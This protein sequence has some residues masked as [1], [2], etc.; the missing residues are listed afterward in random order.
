MC[1]GH[2]LRYSVALFCQLK[3]KL[4]LV[5][6]LMQNIVK[7]HIKPVRLN[8]CLTKLLLN[9]LK[10]NPLLLRLT[11]AVLELLNQYGSRSA[12]HLKLLARTLFL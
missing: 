1:L 2:V 12:L 5:A 3:A 4:I 9:G 8:F 7:L 6:Q 11:L 10:A